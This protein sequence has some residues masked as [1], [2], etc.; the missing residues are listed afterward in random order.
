MWCKPHR[1]RWNCVT[2]RIFTSSP[3]RYN[4][5]GVCVAGKK[6]GSLIAKELRGSKGQS[7][8]RRQQGLQGRTR[9]LREST[10]S[11]AR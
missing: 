6:R 7:R 8:Q 4:L 1:A 3:P 11:R 2:T 5:K 10:E 9:A